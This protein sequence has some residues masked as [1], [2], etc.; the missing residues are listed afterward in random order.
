MT[1]LLKKFIAFN[2]KKKANV[3][4]VIGKSPTRAN[5][6]WS[7]I[8]P[9]SSCKTAGTG[10]VA[11][12]DIVGVKKTAR[13]ADFANNRRLTFLIFVQILKSGTI[14]IKQTEA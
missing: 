10:M 11:G 8:R 9:T 7:P 12:T 5:P 2:N 6:G 3:T 13:Q 4:T 1:G 14:T